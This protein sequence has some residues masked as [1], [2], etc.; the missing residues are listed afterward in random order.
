MPR[1]PVKDGV[2]ASG[3]LP[4]GRPN[5]FGDDVVDPHGDAAAVGAPEAG[6]VVIVFGKG[7]DGGAPDNTKVP[8]DPRFEGYGPAGVVL[9]GD[10]GVFHLLAHLDPAAWDENAGSTSLGPGHQPTIDHPA[11]V[12]DPPTL[13]RRYEEGEQIGAMAPHVGA[14]QS[15]T[16]WEVRKTAVDNPSNRALDTFDP[17][18]WLR[19]DGHTNLI[20][21]TLRVTASPDKGIPW[22]VWLVALWAISKSGRR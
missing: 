15:H 20:A 10:S 21:T 8:S 3:F 12:V 18:D 9:K 6:S 13:A 2:V 1:M 17:Q 19:V 14:A 7:A 11:A 22:W 5:H 16:H 4:K